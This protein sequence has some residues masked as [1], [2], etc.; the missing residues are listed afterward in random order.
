[1]AG[2]KNGAGPVAVPASPFEFF[3]S[4]ETTTLYLSPQHW[5]RIKNELDYGAQNELDNA[6]V[7]GFSVQQARQAQAAG[8]Q[9]T[10]IHTNL[11]RQRLLKIALYVDDWN[12]PGPDG[13][14]MRW[15][16]RIDERIAVVKTMKARLASAILAEVDRLIALANETREAEGYHGEPVEAAEE[17]DPTRLAVI[18]G[19]Q[20]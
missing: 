16:H 13:K 1:M 5:V 18:E 9:E 10:L 14:T 6:S 2:S 11:G 19:H 4:D 20:A 3:A 8:E 12:L 15:P 7:T 17:T